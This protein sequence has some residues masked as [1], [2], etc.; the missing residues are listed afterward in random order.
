MATGTG[1]R[2]GAVH[3]IPRTSCAHR[4]SNSAACGQQPKIHT[5]YKAPWVE[6]AAATCCVP[7]RL[8]REARGVVG[9]PSDPFAHLR[10]AQV[11]WIPWSSPSE[12]LTPAARPDHG[13]PLPS[14]VG[15]R[16]AGRGGHGHQ[17]KEVG[18]V[19]S[20]CSRGCSTSWCRLVRQRLLIR[21]A[22][23]IS[24]AGAGEMLRRR[25][26]D[27]ARG[28]EVCWIAGLCYQS[29]ESSH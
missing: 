16:C 7:R 13:S 29:Q 17:T 4:G 12:G 20:C 5:M 23:G 26:L 1:T 14:S 24:K 2:C 21:Q 27:E 28:A 22:D 18:A 6:A 11:L 25:H 9:D 3:R 10:L 8:Q 15:G 19:P